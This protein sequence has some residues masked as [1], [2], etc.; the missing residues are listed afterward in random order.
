MSKM[1]K[2]LVTG[3]AGYIGSFMVRG[4][5]EAGYHPVI[6]DNLSQGHREAVVDFELHKIDL[7]EEP[8]KVD[9]FFGKQKIDGVVH[10]A[11]FI[12]MGE[13]FT[14]PGKYFRNNI[15]GAVNLLNSM[16]KHQAGYFILS[17]SAGVY[18]SPK[19]LPIKEEDPKRPENPYGETKLM[20][21][22]MLDWYNKAHGLRAISIRYFNAAGAALDGEIGEAH[23]NESHIIPLIMKAA[24]EKREFTLF[25]NDYETKDG[26]C[27]RDYIH[28][29]DL[30]EAHV[31]SLKAL[32]DGAGSTAYNA[33]VGRG[34]SNLEI[35]KE[36]EKK[37]GKFDWKFGPRRLG[38]PDSL[39][40]NC[41][42]I[43]K[44]LGWKPKYELGE[45]IDSAYKWHKNNP[46]GYAK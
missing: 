34:Y 5:R 38:D 35:V 44:E 13:S 20:I 8:E 42:K 28:V 18:G 6:I 32:E 27:V 37:T 11:S 29:L 15:F 14:D 16:V 40:A 3:G 45:I 31:L 1:K 25:G 10:M 41:A 4:L 9:R 19:K 33:G 36:I 26:T 21:E 2:I 46:K 22:R 24:L 23:P 7:V 17:S 39:Y 12:Q 43:R 30:V